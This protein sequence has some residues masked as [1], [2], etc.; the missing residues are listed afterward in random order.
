MRCTDHVR[1]VVLVVLLALLALETSLDLG[2][3]ADALAFLDQGYVLADLDRLANDLVPN[4]DR[5]RALAPPTGDCVHITTADTA[6]LDQHVHVMVFK[7]LGLDL[8]RLSVTP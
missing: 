4:T 7:L 3:D 1:A 6:R 2:A 8:D 5:Q